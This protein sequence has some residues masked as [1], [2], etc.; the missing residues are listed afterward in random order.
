MT[1]LDAHLS[2]AFDDDRLHRRGVLRIAAGGLLLAANGLLLPEWLEEAEAREG[3]YDGALGGRRGK[4]H[5]GRDHDRE[6][7]RHRRGREKEPDRDKRPD[8][9]PP[10]GIGEGVLNIKFVVYNDST[11]PIT[12][13]RDSKAWGTSNTIGWEERTVPAG[14]STAFETFVKSALLFL[15]NDRHYV[16][17]KNFL[18]GYPTV[19]IQSA[20]NRGGAGPKDMDVGDTLS[21]QHGAY[22]IDVKRESDESSNKVFSVRY[23]K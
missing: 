19:E 23:T 12:A 21:W 13:L 4:N 20:G 8:R 1:T 9:D 16:W 3:A 15:D 2:E 17:A 6:R 18:L 7:R 11:G 22:K 10:K 5:R 14:G